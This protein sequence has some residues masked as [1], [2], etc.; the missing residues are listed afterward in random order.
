MSKLTSLQTKVDK[1]LTKLTP[2]PYTVY[3]RYTKRVGGDVFLGRSGAVQVADFILA[4]QPYVEAVPPSLR[5]NKHNPSYLMD[6][7]LIQAGDYVVN[8]SSTA[9]SR[10]EL[11]NPDI[12]LVFFGDGVEDER[13]VVT[14]SSDTIFGSEVLF[15]VLARVSKRVMG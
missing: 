13:S 1:A 4:P 9:M 3:K 5:I 2:T 12:L 15:I 8:I 14:F 11:E 6:N 10:S 7:S